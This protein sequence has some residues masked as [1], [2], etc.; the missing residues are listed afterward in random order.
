MEAAPNEQTS[1]LDV[2]GAYTRGHQDRR[3]DVPRRG[4]AD[5]GLGQAG[6]EEGD[7]AELPERERRGA[8]RGRERQQRARCENDADALAGHLAALPGSVEKR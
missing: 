7:A 8:P 1:R 2:N 3:E 6:G 5:A 4:G